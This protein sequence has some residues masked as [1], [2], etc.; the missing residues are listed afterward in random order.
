M[1]LEVR[2]GAE[3]RHASLGDKR[4]KEE[5]S[6]GGRDEGR[7]RKRLGGRTYRKIEMD[8]LCLSKIESQLLGGV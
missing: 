4:K 5:E 8:S 7:E 2:H 1:E 6:K 3:D